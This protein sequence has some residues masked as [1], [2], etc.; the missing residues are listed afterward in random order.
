MVVEKVEITGEHTF[1][2]ETSCGIVE[3]RCRHV[4][5]AD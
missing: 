4:S 1:R 5:V 2:Q 3:P